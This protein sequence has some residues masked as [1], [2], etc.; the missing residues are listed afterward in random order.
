M[1]ITTRMTRGNNGNHAP[2]TPTRYNSRSKVRSSVSSHTT[3]TTSRKLNNRTLTTSRIKVSGIRRHNQNAGNGRNMV[4]LY[5]QRHLDDHARGTRR[6]STRRRRRNYRR[7][8]HNRN[9]VRTRQTSPTN[10]LAI[11]LSRRTKGR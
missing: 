11:I 5:I 2:Y 1:R 8:T 4:N 3:S 6:Q 7:R 10:T 9:R